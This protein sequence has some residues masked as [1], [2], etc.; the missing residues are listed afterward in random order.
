VPN[1]MTTRTC[2]QSTTTDTRAGG[3]RWRLRGAL[4]YKS[5]CQRS[6]SGSKIVNVRWSVYGGAHVSLTSGR[7]TP[8]TC[9]RRRLSTSLADLRTSQ[10]RPSALTRGNPDL[11]SVLFIRSGTRG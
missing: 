9:C 2:S 6:C 11:V 1:G 3:Q 5:A 8:G 4:R 10:A 7:A